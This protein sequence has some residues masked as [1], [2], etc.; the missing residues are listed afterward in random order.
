MSIKIALIALVF[1]TTAHAASVNCTMNFPDGTPVGTADGAVFYPDGRPL[2]SVDGEVLY[3]NGSKLLSPD[4]EMTYTDGTTLKTPEGK[5]MYYGGAT[6][7]NEKGETFNDDG[8]ANPLVRYE[9]PYDETTTLILR[10]W[11]RGSSYKLHAKGQ[12]TELV[13]SIDDQSN[14][15]CEFI[16]PIGPKH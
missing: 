3:P 1:A 9:I 4:G 5:V 10:A 12:G 2:R 11:K 8:T 7:R 15:S 14:I 6:L 16:K 13:V